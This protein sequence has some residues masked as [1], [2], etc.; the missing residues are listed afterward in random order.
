MATPKQLPDLWKQGAD[1]ERLYQLFLARLQANDADELVIDAC[2]RIRRY[3]ARG[4]GLRAAA[5]TFFFEINALVKRKSYRIAWRQMQLRD[6]VIR[7]RRVAPELRKWSPKDYSE[8]RYS[9]APLMYFLGR[10][11]AGSRFLET[12]LRFWYARPRANSYDVLFDVYNT[13]A[14]PDALPRVTL[15]HF[16]C[17]LGRDLDEWDLWPT[18]VRGFAAPLFRISG[19]ERR[20]LLSDPSLLSDFFTKLVQVRSARTTSGVSRGQAD[21]VESA[22]KVKRWQDATRAKLERFRSDPARA[23]TQRLI[24][25]HFGEVEDWAK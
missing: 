4:P 10:Y 24:A 19:I 7:G 15:S 11:E 3:A 18:F 17:H 25:T 8:L 12:A 14:E 1:A 21:I 5:F 9:Y 20:A 23:Q 13:D 2:R 16:Y 6:K 22:E